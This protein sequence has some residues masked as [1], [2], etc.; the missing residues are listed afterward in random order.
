MIRLS[1][2]SRCRWL[3]LGL[4]VATP[5]PAAEPPDALA[6]VR[7]AVRGLVRD[8][9]DKHDVPGLSLALVD[10]DRVLWAEGFGYADEKHQ[11][12]A[13]PETLFV[14]GGLTQ[15]LTAAVTLQLAE[16][17]AIGLDRPLRDQLPGFSIRSRFDAAPPITPR[18]LLSHH[19]GLP[20]MHL[21]GM[22][23]PQPEP[24][25]DFVARLKDE[26]L[27]SPPGLVYAPS[28][29]GY[30][31]LGRLIEEHCGMAYAAC[32][33][34]KLLQPLGMT[35]STFDR[36]GADPALLARHYW[37]GEEVPFTGVRDVPAGG[38][39]SNVLE[40]G[41]FARMLLAHGR[42]DGRALLRAASVADM[43]R[44]QNADVAL[45]LDHRVGMPWNLTGV[46]FPQAKRVAWLSNNSP[47]A[48][49]RIVLLPEQ[50]LGLV[51]MTNSS[52]S[53][54][55][56]RVISE[57]L[58]QL[59]LEQRQ[60]QPAG[61][62]ASPRTPAALQA[63]EPLHTTDLSG[64]FA[65]TLGHIA[66]QA[67]GHG[68][69]AS[70]FGKTIA[71]LPQADGLFAAQYRLLGLIPIPIDVLDQVRLTTAPVAG[72]Q[73][74]IA[75]YRDQAYRLGERIRPVTLSPAW[76]RRL[77]EYAAVERD[78]LLDLIK[79]GNIYLR[80]ENGLLLFHYRVPGWLGLVADVPVRP[81][82]DRELVVEGTGWMMGDTVQVVERD[83]RDVLRYSG[84]EYRRVNPH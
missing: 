72:R 57:R 23:A 52:G 67:D 18:L 70:L 47:F 11:R 59:V 26:Y 40:L 22:W 21:R 19:A 32:V 82:N 58:L 6:A 25:G 51:V 42:F 62:A 48:R 24:F 71:L 64:D 61:P 35:R 28:F 9:M 69:R 17:Q 12:K 7:T 34:R 15:A 33:T 63:A 1:F 84:Y 60:P 53:T 80:Y 36:A 13:T 46:R 78:P 29:P 30:D 79:L 54:E 66:L 4:A 45:D 5:L 16:Q 38:L 2:R 10:A 77:G 8:E 37:E 39:V 65:T 50:P 75:Y 56:V 44:A 41:R 55:A 68:Y 73:L 81:V 20:A 76:Q 27:A 49:G 14:A 83:G 3:A 43:L 74:A 31:V